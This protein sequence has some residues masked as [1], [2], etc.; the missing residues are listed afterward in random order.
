V[1]AAT[2]STL[3]K[4]QRLILNGLTLTLWQLQPQLIA[5]P[6]PCLNPTTV[7]H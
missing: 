3:Y 6:L 1:K 7:H 5:T 4:Y 2:E